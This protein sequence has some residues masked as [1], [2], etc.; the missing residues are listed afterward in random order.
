MAVNFFEDGIVD[1]L[2]NFSID[3]TDVADAA[4]IIKDFK[5]EDQGALDWISKIYKS[6][7]RCKNQIE[8]ERKELTEP[9]RGEI[10]VINLKAKRLLEPVDFVINMANAK[11]AAYEAARAEQKR[12]SDLALREEADLFEAGESLYIPPLQKNIEAQEA[13]AITKVEKKFKVVND[14]EVPRKYLKIDEDAIK[15][16]IKL[17]IQNIPGIEIWEE[18][19]TTLR[20]K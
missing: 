4:K 16:D 8:A 3:T 13:T 10:S 11:V 18:T 19:K 9:L 17:G 15:Q 7:R 20:I 12:L 6:A 1:S 5:I 2:R 14:D